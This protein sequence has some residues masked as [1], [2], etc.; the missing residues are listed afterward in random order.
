VDVSNPAAPQLV[1]EVDTGP[2]YDVAVQGNRAY[3]G[4][5]DL[6]VIDIEDPREPRVLGSLP[7]WGGGFWN[8]VAAGSYLYCCHGSSVVSP[9]VAID[10]TDSENP[11][12][13]G[14]LP[15]GTAGLA[16]AGENYLIATTGEYWASPEFGFRVIDVTDPSSPVGVRLSTPVSP[17]RVAVRG[18]HAYLTENE[19]GLQVVDLA[20]SGNPRLAGHV[21][22]PGYA[23]GLALS[24]DGRF[25]YVGD[26][27]ALLVV[28]VLDPDHPVIAGIAS[29]CIARS[30]AVSGGYA[31]ASDDTGVQVFSLADPRHPSRTGRVS[32]LGG[33]YGEGVYD[34]DAQGTF[35]YAAN[36]LG[37]VV[38]DVMQPSN[39][40][41]VATL[42][43]PVWTCNVALSDHWAVVASDPSGFHVVDIAN[44][45]QPRLV[46]S[47]G[48][49]GGAVAVADGFAYVGPGAGGV[50]VITL[51]DTANPRIIGGVWDPGWPTMRP[52]P[53]TTSTSA[54]R[55]GCTSCRASAEQRRSP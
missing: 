27:T 49:S 53:M 3:V 7:D 32:I 38:I 43:L 48:Q 55:R 42:T 19:S 26:D 51:A 40:R 37:L 47:V 41:V 46:A 34:I 54:K 13:V 44:P 30:V 35:V 15:G 2:S 17:N 14:A 52:S 25:V 36:G 29:G 50:D 28:D 12:V 4:A 11:R 16:L 45:T 23:S 33:L 8:L 9:V 10:I 20:D 24:Q 31:Y 22:T 18:G 21:D 39:P 5:R 6:V 1:A